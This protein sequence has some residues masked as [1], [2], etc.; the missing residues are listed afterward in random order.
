VPRY[1]DCQRADGKC[2]DCSLSSYGKDCRNNPANPIAYYRNLRGL[3]Q[4][5]LADNAGL[6]IRQVQKFEAGVTK[7]ENAQYNTLKALASAL[8]VTIE[9]IV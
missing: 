4:Q 8:G 9:D 7:T 2:V 6:N 3:T 5:Q 1:T